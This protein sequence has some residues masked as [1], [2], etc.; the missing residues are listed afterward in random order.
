MTAQ[1]KRVELHAELKTLCKNVY[2][3][4]PSNTSMS[5]P[6]FVYKLDTISTYNADDIKYKS[7]RRYTLTYITCDPDDDAIENILIAF[8]YIRFDRSFNSDGLCHFVYTLY[9]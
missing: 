5:Y 2:Y 4:P 1:N 8:P 6:C 3:T 9:Y 7:N